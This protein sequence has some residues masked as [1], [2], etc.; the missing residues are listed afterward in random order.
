MPSDRPRLAPDIYDVVTVDG[1][2][3]QD[4]MNDFLLRFSRNEIEKALAWLC[5]RGHLRKCGDKVR[6]IYVRRENASARYTNIFP[7]NGVEM[8]LQMHSNFT[9]KP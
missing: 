5:Q 8:L 2:Y 4:V 9:G 7:A 1:R 6:P 3:E